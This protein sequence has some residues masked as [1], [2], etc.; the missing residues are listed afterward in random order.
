MTSKSKKKIKLNKVEADKVKGYEFI[1][2]LYANIFISAYKKSGKTTIIYNILKSCAGKETII[3]FFV[4]TFF[5]DE[6]YVEISKML[7]KKEIKHHAFISIEDNLKNILQEQ[8]TITDTNKVSEEVNE[9][10]EKMKELQGMQ[11]KIYQRLHIDEDTQEVQV[12]VQ[13]PKKVAPNIIFVFDDISNEIRNNKDVRSLLKMNRHFKSK[14][15]I[16]S[17]DV[18]DLYP[19]SRDQ[20]DIWIIFK[21]FTE[22]KLLEIYKSS[23]QSISFIK[24]ME[25]YSNATKEKYNFLMIDKGNGEYRKNFNLEYQT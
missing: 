13:K 10:K 8:K 11:K 7:D 14:T 5:R 15:I 2:E 23:H 25:F 22:D 21:G 17:Q 4:S 16:S 24:F 20:I 19:D 3:Y 9:A 6:S 12:K 1:P 18:L